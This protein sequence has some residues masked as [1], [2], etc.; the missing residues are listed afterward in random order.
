M[1]PALK[2]REQL[3][4]AQAI[5]LGSGTIEQRDRQRLVS[6]LEDAAAGPRGGRAKPVKPEN[7][8]KMGIGVRAAE[9]GGAQNG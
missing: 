3:D 4:Q 7:A 8:A 5:A 2:A 9:P 1:M 6:A